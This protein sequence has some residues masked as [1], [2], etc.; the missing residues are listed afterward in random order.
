MIEGE[1]EPSE[2][3]DLLII[4]HY[5]REFLKNLQSEIQWCRGFLVP[6]LCFYPENE[7]EG[8]AETAII[9]R[10]RPWTIRPNGRIHSLAL[11][12]LALVDILVVE[13][14]ISHFFV[15]KQSAV[16]GYRFFWLVHAHGRRQLLLPELPVTNYWP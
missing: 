1:V 4:N 3:L 12:F 15:E 10:Y 8:E 13:M 5:L 9:G 16:C 14:G 11:T 6:R 7:K 2:S